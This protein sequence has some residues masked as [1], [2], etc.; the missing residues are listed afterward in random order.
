LAN[1][2]MWANWQCQLTVLD[3]HW[4]KV[5]TIASGK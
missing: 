5:W 1:F 4:R 3:L 2:E